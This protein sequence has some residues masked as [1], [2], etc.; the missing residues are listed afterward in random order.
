MIA[1]LTAGYQI[2]PRR[3]SSTR[4]GQHV[5]QGQVGGRILPAAVLAGGMVPQKDILSGQRASLKGDVDVLCQPDYCGRMNRQFCR[6]QHMAIALF[7]AR[8]S[9]KDH[10]H[11]APFGAHIDGLK[12]GI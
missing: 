11:C 6:V 7:D 4:A 10:H 12:R 3:L 5:V 9:L 8:N 2:I 1:T